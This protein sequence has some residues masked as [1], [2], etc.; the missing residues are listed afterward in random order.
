MT[1]ASGIPASIEARIRAGGPVL[2]LPLVHSLYQQALEDQPRDGV[3]VTRDLPYGPHERHRVDIFRPVD[4]AATFGASMIF[5]HGGG[6]IRGDK[7]GRDNVGHY[8]ARHGFVT[9]VANY[10]LA[11]AHTWPA[12]AQDVTRALSWAQENISRWGGNPQR[13]FVAGESA[14]AAH[15]A[16]ATL[17]KRFH[18]PTGLPPAGAV[19]ISGV[20]NVLLEAMARRQF[21]VPTPDPRNDAY[22]GTNREDFPGMSTVDLVDAAPF[23]LFMSYAE[24]DMVQ[25]QVQAGELFSRLVT[26]HGFDPE[27]AVIRGHNH[28]SQVYSINTGDDS[29]GGPILE[30]LKRHG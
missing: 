20:Y 13:V 4:I 15:V 5:L 18:S 14:G 9:L 6:F 1:D 3:D 16:L 25:M 27:L 28:L 29:L 12:G 19:L 22:F 2:D 24:L 8:F 10:R 21:A 11:P 26:R 7:A 17:V 30:F 23:P